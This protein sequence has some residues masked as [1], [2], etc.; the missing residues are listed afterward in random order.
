M[1]D[2]L[3]VL[4]LQMR[5]DR[6]CRRTTA[7]SHR[8]AATSLQPASRRGSA[9]ASSEHLGRVCAPAWRPLSLRSM[10]P[11][12][13]RPPATPR[14]RRCWSR[15]TA[16]DSAAIAGSIDISTPNTAARSRRSAA[17]SSEYGIAEDS[18]A[19]AAPLPR[20]DGRTSAEP[21]ADDAVRRQPDRL[22]RQRDREARHPREHSTDPLREQ[23]VRRPARTGRD[24]KDDADR[25]EMAAAA[26]QQHDAGRRERHPHH[27]E[28]HGATRRSRRRA[29]RGTRRSPRRRAGSGRA[30]RRT[31]PFIAASTRPKPTTSSRSARAS[32]R[33]RGRTIAATST[34]DSAS[35]RKTAPPGPTAGNSLVATAAP[36]CTLAIRADDEHRGRHH[37]RPM[38]PPSLAPR[39]MVVHGAAS[40]RDPPQSRRARHGASSVPARCLS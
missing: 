12:P 33:T 17:S 30:T 15:K 10:R 27:V 32:P 2:H 1:S 5:R 23:D 24:R 8:P 39:G 14:Q 13:H 29:V 25:V 7:R 9:P 37:L 6:R 38:H 3:D 36:L 19:I 20:I 11:S 18:T 34:A 26:G 21:P 35:R 16:P 40:R 4:E 31:A 22:R 28:R